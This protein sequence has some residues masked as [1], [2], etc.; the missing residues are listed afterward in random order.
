MCF[1]DVYKRQL[2]GI[3]ADLFDHIGIVM[4]VTAKLCLADRHRVLYAHRDSL[5]QPVGQDDSD[6]HAQI[7]AVVGRDLDEPM[8]ECAVDLWNGTILGSEEVNSPVG[9]D[10]VVQWFCVLYDLD[11]HRCNPGLEQVERLITGAPLN[12]GI[13]THAFFPRQPVI[14]MGIDPLSCPQQVV[15]SRAGTGAQDLSLIHI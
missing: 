13:P 15:N 9:M 11:R 6:S 4:L 12:I 5:A 1:R 10:E 2:L 3:P 8:A 7:E 14:V